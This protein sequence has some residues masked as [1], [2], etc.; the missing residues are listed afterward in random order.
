MNDTIYYNGTVI[1]M[2]GDRMAQAVLVADGRIAAVGSNTG[3][4]CVW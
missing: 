1:T 4:M 3:R 2:D